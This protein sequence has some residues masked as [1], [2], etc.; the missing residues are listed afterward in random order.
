MTELFSGARRASGFEEEAEGPVEPGAVELAA[1]EVAPEPREA[2]SGQKQRPTPVPAG[3]VPVGLSGEARGELLRPGAAERV[4]AGWGWRGLL[5]RGTG[6]L[7]AVRPGRAEQAH[8]DAQRVIRQATWSRSVNVLV[9]GKTGGVG[10]TTTSIVLAGTLGQVRGGAT[11]AF[12]VADATGALEKR[13]EGSPG[14]GMGELVSSASSVASAGALAGYAAPQTS[15]AHV[16]G[17]VHDRPVLTGYDVHAVREVLDRYYRLTVADSGNNPHSAAF[18]AAAEGADVLVM[19][20]LL[21]SVAVLDTLDVFEAIWRLG[22]HGARL[23]QTAVIVINHDGRPEDRTIAAGSRLELERVREV[24]PDVRILEVPFDAHVAKGGEITLAS[25]S[26]GSDQA[27]MRV[28]AG[29]TEQLLA[30]VDTKETN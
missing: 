11:A 2:T 17:S 18:T 25:M 12:E 24:A 15:L 27:W 29:V 30:N 20:T 16:I 23:A 1:T 8:L 22:D 21:T 10:K 28:A 26:H 14:R 5:V 19:P 7:V 9:A 13:G 4:R 6:G 3:T